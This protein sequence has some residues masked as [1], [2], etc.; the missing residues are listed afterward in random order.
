MLQDILPIIE[1]FLI[2]FQRHPDGAGED[3]DLRR[4][5]YSDLYRHFQSRN[6]VKEVAKT[7]IDVQYYDHLP[8]FRLT[9][10][11]TAYPAGEKFDIAVLGAAG[12]VPAPTS[13]NRF[14]VY[15]EQPVAFALT[16][17]LCPDESAAERYLRKLDKDLKKMDQYQ[18][19]LGEGA[20]FSGV[21]LLMVNGEV[22]E[23]LG[24]PMDIG[25]QAGSQAW[26]VGTNGVFAYSPNA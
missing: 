1:D 11:R 20:E 2:G 8:K 15:W 10:V 5:L 14:Q 9:P 16:L 12:E 24:A 18:A 17:H 7:S 25:F 3:S 21:T 19:G 6:Q 22:P 26:L 13:E 4:D 23:E